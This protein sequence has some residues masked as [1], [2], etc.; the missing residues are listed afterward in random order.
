MKNGMNFFERVHD[1]DP[2]DYPEMWRKSFFTGEVK[3]KKC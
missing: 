2:D 3:Q 1:F